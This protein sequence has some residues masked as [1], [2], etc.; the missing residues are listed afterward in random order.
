MYAIRSYYVRVD[1][2][3]QNLLRAGNR[4]RG[5]LVA[6]LLARTREFLRDLGLRRGLLLAAASRVPPTMAVDERNNFV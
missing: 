5:D 2:A 4:Q 1:L 6:Q 3:L